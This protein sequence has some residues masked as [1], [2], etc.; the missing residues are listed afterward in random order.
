MYSLF[1]GFGLHQ[2]T[3]KDEITSFPIAKGGFSGA[4]EHEDINLQREN[5]SIQ[6]IL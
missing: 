5:T 6:Y 2:R 1:T 4:R 3:Q